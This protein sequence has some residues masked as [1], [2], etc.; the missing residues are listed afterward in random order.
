MGASPI[1]GIPLIASQQAQPEVTHNEAVMLLSIAFLGVIS[2]GLDTPPGSPAEGDAYV[3]GA[4]PT[5]VWTGKAN[6]IAIRYN[7]AW[8]FLPADDEDGTNIPIGASHEGL[9]V[10]DKA[11]N[12]LYIWSGSAW[13]SYTGGGAVSS[14]FGRTGAVVGLAGDYTAALVTNVPA[15]GV[16]AVTVQA[17]IDELDT[18][19]VAKAGDTMT[20]ALQLSGSGGG[21]GNVLLKFTPNDSVWAMEATRTGTYGA[22]QRYILDST[23]VLSGQ[24]IANTQGHAG[25]ATLG[26]PI[27]FAGFNFR[28]ENETGGGNGGLSFNTLVSGT[29]AQ[30]AILK[31]GLSIGTATDPGTG[32][33]N[34]TG[35]IQQSA[36]T[37][38]TANRL[39]RTRRYTVATL[40]VTNIAAGDS[41][42]VTDANSTTIGATVAGGG[43]NLVRV[44]YDGAV[45]KIG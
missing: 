15:G 36:T 43:A 20:G 40:P 21:A 8:Q 24:N 4:A 17:A 13:A 44:S 29:F 10:W 28:A 30:R 7:A 16:A 27:A 25:S 11:T 23:T 2:V 9:R 41:A 14:V 39:I 32:G 19:K 22:F 35:E 31:Q 5:G 12:N 26:A 18:D 3:L 1:F 45:W 34:L 42:L 37:V 6:K 38:L 33:L